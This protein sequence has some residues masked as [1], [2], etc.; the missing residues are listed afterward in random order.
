MKGFLYFF[1]FLLGSTI[2]SQTKQ[3]SVQN[4]AINDEKPHFSLSVN[5]DNEVLFTSWLLNK[6]GKVK[7]YFDEGILRIYTGTKDVSGNIINVEELRIDKKEDIF[8]ISSAVYS[9]NKKK[10]FV[11]TNY[12]NRKNRPKGNYKETNSH[13]EV[14]EYKEGVGWT[15]FKV[16]PFCKP[17]YSYAHPAIG[18]DGKTM[19]FTSNLRG[20][21]ET[22]KGPSDIFK[23]DILQNNTYSEPKNLGAKVNSYS[24]EMFPFMADDNTLYFSS[25]RPNGIGGYDIYKCALNSNGAFET[26]INLSE[27]I[28]S[29]QDDICFI[30]D[31]ENKSGY[32]S[33]KRSEGN[34]EDDI[35]YFTVD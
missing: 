19:Y 2:F 15:N 28:N 10:L 20:G 4:L 9:H 32:F 16:L 3:Y 31:A 35:Y 29:N 21:K 11:T 8:S 25:N 12:I 17:R 30:I 34:G 14:A 23:V 7:T 24:G 27:P 22:T 26:A 18:P 33:S 5:N 1:S 13:I 6:N